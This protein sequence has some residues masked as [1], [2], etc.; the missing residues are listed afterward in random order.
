M[1]SNT[2]IVQDPLPEAIGSDLWIGADA[3]N[4][5]DEYNTATKNFFNSVKWDVLASV[6]SRLRNGLQCSYIDK[7]SIGTFNLVR[8]LDFDDGISWVARVRL[9]PEASPAPP[10]QYD[11]QRAF[12]VE[13]ASMKFFKS[14][15]TIPVPELFA[16]DADPSNEVGVQWMFMEYIHGTTA[17]ELKKIRNSEPMMFGTIEQDRKLREQM[18]KIQAEMFSFTFEEIGSLYYSEDTSS[19]SIGPHLRIE[20]GSQELLLSL[21]ISLPHVFKRLMHIYGEEPEG[22]FRLINADFGAHNVLVDNDFNIV[23]IIDLDSVGTGPLEAAAQYPSLSSMDPEPPDYVDLHPNAQARVELM[24]P[25]MD[26]Y[27][28]FLT[29]YESQLGDGSAPVSHRVGSTSA[30]IYAGFKRCSIPS[31]TQYRKWYESATKLLT[32]NTGYHYNT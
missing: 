19:F 29:K 28:E 5:D 27:K 11:S 21:S 4:P 32:E 18:A 25:R 24:K 26:E 13:A 22:P 10:G 3:Y 30:I 23:S 16:Y 6:A 7:Y 2:T 20:R 8:R 14:K 15:T 17:E 1:D 31:S 12:E 9:P